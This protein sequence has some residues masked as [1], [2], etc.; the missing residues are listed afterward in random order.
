MENNGHHLNRRDLL[1]GA[2]AMA[3]FSHGS[4]AMASNA[5]IPAPDY[6]IPGNGFHGL[7]ENKREWKNDVRSGKVIF[8]AHCALNQNARFVDVA[9]FPAMFEELV[10]FLKE[11]QIGIIQ[12]P[13]P[14]LYCLGLG[15]RDVRPGLENPQGMKRLQR[16]IDDIIFT[17]REYRY[18]DFEV[19]AIMGKEGSPAC[20]VSETWLDERHQ[21]GQG[22]FIRE[23]K[24]RLS[25]EKLDIPVRGIADFRQ[26][27]A[28]EWLKG[29]V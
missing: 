12:M 2:A 23:L 17:I 18:Q 19:V 4:D 29:R 20:G 11:K 6:T 3:A 9:D 21:P 5:E 26:N 25:A 15:R 8:V 27:E 1:S 24:N 13:C 28:I 7:T 14:E 22:V 16:L 10:G